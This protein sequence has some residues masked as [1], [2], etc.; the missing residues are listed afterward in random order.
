MQKKYVIAF[1]GVFEMGYVIF[2]WRLSNNGKLIKN[3]T[4]AE[5]K[6]NAKKFRSKRMANFWCWLLNKTDQDFRTFKVVTL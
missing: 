5:S 6:Q 3:K 2:T 1:T 4:L